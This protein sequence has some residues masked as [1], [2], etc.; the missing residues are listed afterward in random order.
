[1]KTKTISK[2]VAKK[3]AHEFIANA[4]EA[5]WKCS[6]SWEFVVDEHGELDDASW[7]RIIQATE[8]LQLDHVKFS[9]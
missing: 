6:S 7:T 4:I 3:I 5:A 8:E 9:C 2:S 1:M